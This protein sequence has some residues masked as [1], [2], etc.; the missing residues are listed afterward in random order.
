MDVTPLP[1]ALQSQHPLHTQAFME[2]HVYPREAAFNAHATS[3]ERW[4]VPPFVENLK[5]TAQRQGLWNLWIPRPLAAYVPTHKV[6]V[7]GGCEWVAH[8][9]L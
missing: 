1:I 2:E 6:T 8:A 3:R 9:V 5:R 7:C 4:T